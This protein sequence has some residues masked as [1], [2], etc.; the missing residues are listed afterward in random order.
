MTICVSLREAISNANAEADTTQGDCAPGTGNDTIV[1][2]LSGTI[3]LAS[4]LPS[5]QH[6]LEIDGTGQT[7]TIDGGGANSV[8][9][10]SSGA[11][12]LNNL[13]I[14]NGETT[15]NGG[16][17]FNAGPL[18]VTNSTFLGNSA[19]AGGAIF[20]SGSGTLAV[21]NCTF[22]GNSG[23]GGGAIHS[24]H[25]GTVTSSTFSNNSAGVSGAGAAILAN[26]TTVE[27]TNSILSNS[28]GLN[29]GVQSGGVIGNGGYNIS[30]DTSCG[31]GS[32][33]GA[34]GDTI[35][36][37]VNP[38]P[39]T[40]GLQNNG[41]PTDTIALQPNS[42]AVNAVPIADC[43]PT[44]QRGDPRPDPGDMSNACD[45]GAFESIDALGTPTASATPTVTA[46]STGTAAASPTATP[47]ATATVTSTATATATPTATAS[48]TATLT[49]TATPTAT[50][51]ATSTAT[52]TATITITPSPSP[53]PKPPLIKLTISPTSL[54]FG[55]VETGDAPI[56]SVTLHNKSKTTDAIDVPQV[57]GQYFSLASN[58]CETPVPAGG[59]C[60]IGVSF[61]PLAKGKKFTGKLMFTDQSKK[62]GHTVEL[63]GKGVATPTS[64]PSPT[65]SMTSTASIT[66]TPTTTATGGA[67]PTATAT[68][69]PSPSGTSTAT[70]TLESISETASGVVA[71]SNPN[72][73]PNPVETSQSVAV[74]TPSFT[75][76]ISVSDTNVSISGSASA[77]QT[78]AADGSTISADESAA[79]DADLSLCVGPSPVCTAENQG[80]TEMKTVFC[81]ASDT[82]YSLSGSVQASANEDIGNITA[83]GVV[84]IETVGPSPMFIVNEQ[85]TNGQDVPLSMSLPL[86]AGCY[87]MI[88]EV[89][90]DAL[91]SGTGAGSAS[92]SCN[93]L[94]SP[95]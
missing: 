73:A 74:S 67:T 71:L 25:G 93:V 43:P 20:N 77:S 45:I 36:D 47:T 32:S 80:I 3:A 69:T 64:T 1:F 4:G 65:P 59:T 12:T 68:A 6:T 15:G 61:A 89:Y 16:G 66:A 62:S 8:L 57:S 11:L 34:N 31:F 38:L 10:N 86:T 27:V 85:A 7:I 76:S 42:P 51:T 49:A 83:T 92:S 82:N 58:T 17:I 26:N 52:A 90:A 22:S 54:S 48:A 39:A 37:D 91:P 33:L 63:K 46:T 44:D 28:T 88:V 95:Q 79:A 81:I 53:T 78:S 29:C 72:A 18:T 60:Q 55:N 19:A 9:L 5:V 35:G 40:G 14:A 70:Y 41:G 84:S 23:A 50:A 87:D 94:L 2:N 13:T 30:D 75:D 21:T 24:D 56:K